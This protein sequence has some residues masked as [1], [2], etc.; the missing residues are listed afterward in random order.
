MITHVVLFKLADKSPEAVRKVVDVLLGLKGKVPQIRS[1]E[2]GTDVLRSQRSYDIAL[3]A[4]FDSLKDLD[5]YQVH[6]RHKEVEDY[7][8]KVKES[9]AVVDYAS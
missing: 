9:I 5:A 6:P 2:A 7:I 8:A 4:K 1:L 3:I